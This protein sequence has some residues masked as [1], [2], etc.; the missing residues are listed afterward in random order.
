MAPPCPSI[1]SPRG[2]FFLTEGLGVQREGQIWLRIAPLLAT[3]KI[4]NGYWALLDLCFSVFHPKLIIGGI[5]WALL[6]MLKDI[7]ARA[8]TIAFPPA[9]PGPLPN[10]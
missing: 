7:F 9:L 3:P 1:S 6:E 4:G 8:L 5:Y 2:P 10:A